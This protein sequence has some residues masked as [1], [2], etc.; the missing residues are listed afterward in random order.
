MMMTHSQCIAFSPNDAL[1]L[2]HLIGCRKDQRRDG[3]AERR[4]RL[5]VHRQVVSG[6]LL[7]RQVGWAFAF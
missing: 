3:D 2:D 7:D 4:G 5:Q 6:R 1:L